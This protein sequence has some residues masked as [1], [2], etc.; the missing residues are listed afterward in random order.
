M[1]TKIIL[2]AILLFMATLNTYA[3]NAEGFKVTLLK[4][5]LLWTM[6][7]NQFT[8]TEEGN[9]INYKYSAPTG[10]FHLDI[11]IVD[12]KVPLSVT[13]LTRTTENMKNNP[14][15][16]DATVS[17]IADPSAVFK[18]LKTS[19]FGVNFK[20]NNAE[21]DYYVFKKDSYLITVI[22][23]HKA[24]FSALDKKRI[25]DFTNSFSIQNP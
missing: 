15:V 13:V 14:P 17:Y 21:V 23:A 20:S 16:K 10:N 2:S 3:Q 24:S 11:A 4:E 12:Y 8:K 6:P 1:K 22:I 5:G 19:I 18:G 7:N 25:D 9:E